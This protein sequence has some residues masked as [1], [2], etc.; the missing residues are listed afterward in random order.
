LSSFL[1]EKLIRPNTVSPFQIVWT[2]TTSFSF[3]N[4]CKTILQGWQ[5]RSLCQI[6]LLLYCV[7]SLP[8]ICGCHSYSRWTGATTTK[9]FDVPIFTQKRKESKWSLPKEIGK[10]NVSWFPGGHPDK[11][12]LALCPVLTA[13][14]PDRN[15][16]SFSN[17]EYTTR[18]CFKI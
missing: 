1:I 15:M 13:W 3:V 7:W 12:L 2:E 10:W 14:Q 6:I 5:K 4:S 18:W 8:V 17:T 16:D 9:F 11:I